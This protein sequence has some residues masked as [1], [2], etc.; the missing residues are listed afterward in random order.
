[1][2]GQDGETTKKES[3]LLKIRRCVMNN[4]GDDDSGQLTE[5]MDLLGVISDLEAHVKQA[6]EELKKCAIDNV[7]RLVEEGGDPSAIYWICAANGMAKVVK[8]EYLNTTGVN[9]VP[10]SLYA[11]IYCRDCGSKG[12]HVIK[13]ISGLKDWFSKSVYPLFTCDDCEQKQAE[14]RKKYSELRRSREAELANMPYREY[15]KTP[16]WKDRR[17]KALSF[18]KHRCQLCNAS[19]VQLDVHH[20]TYADRGNEKMR[21]LIVLCHPCHSKHHDKGGY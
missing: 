18:A 16:E 8:D 11:P 13:S 14:A 9:L 4:F 10:K 19:G 2:I 7:C 15:L 12:E 20:R 3:S 6:K 5:M 1:M 17:V 21:D